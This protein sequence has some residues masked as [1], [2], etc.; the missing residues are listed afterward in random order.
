MMAVHQTTPRHWTPAEVALVQE[1]VERSWAI[2]ERARAESEVRERARL[3]ALRA[4]IAAQLASGDVLD[5]S[6]EACCE[7]FVHHL[8]AAFA[9][10]W[11]LGPGESVL[12][13]RASAG[14]YTHL[15]G[16]HARVPVGQFKIGRIAQNQQPLLTNEVADDPNI[17]DPDWAK[18]EGMIAF[19]G[20]PLLAEDQT[21][22]VL[23]MFARQSLSPTTLADL[24][25]I[26]DTLAIC[27]ERKRAESELA[28]G[29]RARGK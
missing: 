24:A 9:R 18:R 12:E 2:I 3:S 11:T 25:P 5:R 4:D 26:A 29:D 1:V 17:S 7:F 10:V 27:I 14:I 21:V 20:Y 19:A 23:A 6:L 28:S 8:G 16:P 13:L 15:N 22:G